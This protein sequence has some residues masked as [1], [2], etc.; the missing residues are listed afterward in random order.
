MK[1]PDEIQAI[2]KAFLNG[3]RNVLGDNLFGVYLFGAIAFL[4]SGKIRD[5]D[6][7]VIINHPLN[8]LEKSRLKAL[9]ELIAGIYPPLG[10]ELDGY[11][12]LL[13]DVHKPSPPEHQ[14]LPG[15]TDNSWAL[16]RAHLRAGHC[17]VLVGPDP[18]E[19]YPE[20]SWD[21][22]AIALKGESDYVEK[23]LDD[24]PDYC[25]LNL[26][27]LMYS[28]STR[29]VVTSKRASA[30]WAIGVFPEYKRLIEAAVKSYD[31]RITPEEIELLKSEVYRY[32]NF[33][34]EFIRES[35]LK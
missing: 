35:Y 19:I 17:F 21:E 30:K 18:R 15:V 9:H 7:H 1:V 12:I 32:F 23:H 5:I 8:D 33:A 13:D 27:R 6:F 4:E 25:V 26:C 20:P 14:F 28:F 3:L 24:Y 10:G 22:L 34:C 31:E 2:C 16:H 29:D 11:Y